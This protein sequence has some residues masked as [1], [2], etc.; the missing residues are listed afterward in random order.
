VD[1]DELTKLGSMMGSG[2]MIVMDEDT[3]MVNVA[4]YFTNFLQKESC[5]KC[6]PCR[7]GLSQMLY[8]LDRITDGEGQVGDVERLEE[9]AELLE[10]TALCALGK[11]AANP[12]ISTIRYFRDEY[13]A[14]IKDKRCPAKECR[15]LF[16]YDI[17]PEACK[18]C[19]I[20]LKDCPVDAITGEKKVPHVIDQEKCTLCGTCWE[21]CP[22]AAVLKV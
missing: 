16:R 13:E 22:F 9:L 4:K 17:D 3:C 7:E 14:H 10:G 15:G 8:I 2:G 18:A 6:T 5:G 1:F 11:T 20:C 19:G 12:I 21:K